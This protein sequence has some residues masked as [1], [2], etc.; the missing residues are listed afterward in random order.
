MNSAHLVLIIDIEE[1][2]IN[3]YMT[4]PIYKSTPV[5]E[6]NFI[7]NDRCTVQFI[8][9]NVFYLCKSNKIMFLQT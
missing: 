7:S 1:T 9:N 3:S 6:Y 4:C 2:N 5:T 8:Y